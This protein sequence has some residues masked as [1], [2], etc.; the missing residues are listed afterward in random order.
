MKLFYINNSQ[1]V[2]GA[3]F[4]VLQGKYKSRIIRQYRANNAQLHRQNI[5]CY[6]FFQLDLNIHGLDYFLWNIYKNFPA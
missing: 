2:D 5:H 1:L 6:V 3:S 4:V